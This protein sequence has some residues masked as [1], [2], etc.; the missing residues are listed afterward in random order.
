MKVIFARKAEKELSKIGENNA[1]K[2]LEYMK[3][4]SE[5]E[6]PRSRG[7]ALGYNLKGFWRYRVEDYRVFCEILDDALIISVVRIE[8]R[9]DVYDK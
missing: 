7:K 9:R 1:R 8:H 6:N 2:I 3:E 5:L 4:V